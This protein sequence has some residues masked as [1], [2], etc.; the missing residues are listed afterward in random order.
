MPFRLSI[1][2]KIS[3]FLCLLLVPTVFLY[4]YANQVGTGVIEREIKKSYGSRLSFFI[5]QADST[6]DQLWK[7][8]FNLCRDP[9]AAKLMFKSI[10]NASYDVLTTK[11]L[12]SAKADLQSNT[13]GWNNEFTIFAPETGQ[14]ISTNSLL[15]Y[16]V[17]HLQSEETE[18]WSYRRIVT[19]QGEG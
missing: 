15:Q 16:D 4:S 5:Q 12:I 17:E 7:A 19:D 3:I 10:R 1:F 2:N 9:D 18:T 13:F 11:E 8:A 6:A 14:T